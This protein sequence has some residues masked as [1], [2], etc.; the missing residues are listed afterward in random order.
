[1]HR[2]F[3]TMILTAAAVLSASL[4]AA[5]TPQEPRNDRQTVAVSVSPRTILEYQAALKANPNDPVTHNLL[6]I[7]YQRTKRLNAS[8]KEYKEAVKLNAR[9]AEAWNNLGSAYH[10]KGKLKDAVK[11]YR[12]AIEIKPDMAPAH[13]N[14]GTALLAMGKIDEGLA[15]CRRAFELSPTVFE[16]KTDISVP[17]LG[18]DLAAQYYYFAKLSAANGRVDAALDFLKKAQALGFCDFNKVK[19]DPD[20][21][22]VVADARFAG[23]TR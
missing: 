3:I 12:K 20:F 8:I 18:A 2:A 6:G 16:S 5:S 9:Y 21:K 7:C 4:Q 15:A 1:M 13:K 22:T 17:T 23:L 11:Y 10:A 14:L 19:R